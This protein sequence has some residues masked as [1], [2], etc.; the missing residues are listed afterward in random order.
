MLSRPPNPIPAAFRSFLRPRGLTEDDNRVQQRSL[1][2]ERST[3][4][5]IAAF[6]MGGHVAICY[7]ER[8]WRA[9][10]GVII[11][12]FRHIPNL[13]AIPRNEHILSRSGVC[14]PTDD[15]SH[16]FRVPQ[17]GLFVS[18]AIPFHFFVSIGTVRRDGSLPSQAKPP[19][20]KRGGSTRRIMSQ[21]ANTMKGRRRDHSIVRG[22]CSMSTH[23]PTRIHVSRFPYIC[24]HRLP[25]RTRGTVKI[26][27]L[28]PLESPTGR[29][30]RRSVG[31]I[32]APGGTSWPSP[33]DKADV[34][35]K[36]RAACAMCGGVVVVS[37]STHQS[38]RER[39]TDTGSSAFSA[40]AERRSRRQRQQ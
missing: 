35:R 24:S 10:E 7:K 26:P 6:K 25:L 1:A 37:S 5:K 14:H 3:Q 33:T 16:L 32:I 22:P 4:P 18:D 12:S 21:A 38:N 9:S 2:R 39:R 28:P 29:I 15:P 8:W 11:R 19:E 34:G 27:V 20:G 23:V 13:A 31:I 40:C 30:K 36:T 17:D